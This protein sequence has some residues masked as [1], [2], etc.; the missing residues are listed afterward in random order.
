MAKFV[1]VHGGGHGGWCWQRLA[2]LLRA[3]GH[4][5]YTPTLTGL[6]ERAH[7]L[8]AAIDLD[9]HITDIVAVLKYEGLSEV[10]VS[11]AWS[12]LGWRIAPCRE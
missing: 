5:V 1:L 7:L 11:A 4:D 6:G 8:N 2:P 12:S 9:T 3:G 10:T